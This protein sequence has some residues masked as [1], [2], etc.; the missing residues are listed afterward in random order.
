MY[1][2]A[3]YDLLKTIRPR[4]WYLTRAYKTIVAMAYQASRRST[5]NLY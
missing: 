3:E 2:A 4:I 1:Q 5:C